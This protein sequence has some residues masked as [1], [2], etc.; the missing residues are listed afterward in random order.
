MKDLKITKG[1]WYDTFNVSKERGVRT[2][3]GFICFLPKPFHYTGQDERYEEEL[4][5]YKA[6]AKLIAEAGNVANETGLMPKELLDERDTYKAILN[7][8]RDAWLSNN[9]YHLN[10]NNIV[11]AVNEAMEAFESYLATE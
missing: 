5:E 9:T 8:I 10:A 7:D 2:E 11:N 6:N 1:E 3:H 4:E